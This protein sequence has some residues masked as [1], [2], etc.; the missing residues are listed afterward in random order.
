[1]KKLLIGSVAFLTGAIT[2][3]LAI[4]FYNKKN[5]ENKEMSGENKFRL[6]YNVA[7]GWLLLKNSKRSLVE[8]FHRNDI[9]KIAI[10]GMGE[11]GC[12][13]LEEMSESDVEVV[14]AIDAKPE[15]IDADINVLQVGTPIREE[16]DAIVVTA[17]FAYNNIEKDL[18]K[19]LNC[20]IISLKDVIYSMI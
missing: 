16:V 17:V 7:N 14:C 3:F 13:F 15:N 10:Y 2:S 18:K 1:M 8:Y 9:K 5:K 4:K 6:Y 11:L 19:Y 12:R 20:R